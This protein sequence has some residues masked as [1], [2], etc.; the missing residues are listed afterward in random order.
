VTVGAG[1]AFVATLIT[2]RIARRALDDIGENLS[3]LDVQA[4]TGLRAVL[5]LLLVMN[6]FFLT[7]FRFI[8]SASENC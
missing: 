4:A 1:I 6:W 3:A 8:T 5:V 7:G 2:W